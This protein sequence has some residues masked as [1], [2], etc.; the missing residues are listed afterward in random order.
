MSLQ[1]LSAGGLCLFP[2]AQAFALTGPRGELGGGEGHGG[3]G[4]EAEK[5]WGTGRER[6]RGRQ[7]AKQTLEVADS[8]VTMRTAE[9][10][11]SHLRSHEPVLT[12]GNTGPP[13][14]GGLRLNVRR[15]LPQDR[16]GC[17]HHILSAL[18]GQDV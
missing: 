15:A 7:G 14:G 16:H 2:L 11:G 1:G 6:G 10:H 17:P 3:V 18:E 13:L 8:F 12:V 5:K 9:V 4:R